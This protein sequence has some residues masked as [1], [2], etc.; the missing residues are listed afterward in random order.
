MASLAVAG[1][2]PQPG[3]GGAL[4][5]RMFPGALVLPC[6]RS[7]TSL[8]AAEAAKGGE[9]LERGTLPRARSRQHLPLCHTQ[10]RPLRPDSRMLPPRKTPT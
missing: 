7:V 6:S 10:S 2:L 4:V 8:L 5:E 1:A 9:G 3:A